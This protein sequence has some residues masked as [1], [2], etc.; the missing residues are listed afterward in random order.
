M[1]LF[2]ILCGCLI[3]IALSFV[4]PPL[5][6]RSTKTN[7]SDE[8]RRQ[9][10]IAIY[11]DQLSELESDLTN[12]IVSG[13]QY[14]QDRQEIQRRLLEDIKASD[15]NSKVKAKQQSRSTVY[16][17][18]LG[19]PLI[20]V[21][22][23]LKVGE[24]KGISKAAQAPVETQTGMVDDGRSQQQIEANVAALAKRLESNP[25]DGEGWQMLARSYSSM[26]R[27]PEAAEAYGKATAIIT[28]NADLWAEYAFATAMA[29]GRQLQGKPMEFIS[30]ALK[31]DPNNLKALEL[32]GTAAFQANDYKKAIEYWQQVVDKVPAG[33]DVAQSVTSR[34]N[35][36]KAKLN[37]K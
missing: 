27:W 37:Q 4:L 30:K 33:S 1:I 5:L 26:E 31:L 10:N 23:Y 9:A 15:N 7:E 3:L 18:A 2:W 16:V 22:F 24:P 29:S 35:E 8:E 19:I 34:I 28:D 17:V 11:K 32:S 25:S 13:E 36:A 20:A 21:L 14:E 12:G 6:Q